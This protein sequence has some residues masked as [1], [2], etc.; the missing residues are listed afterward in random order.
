MCQGNVDSSAIKVIDG[1][2]VC[3]NCAEKSGGMQDA[4]MS[5]CLA[6]NTQ[7]AT[8]DLVEKDGKKICAACASH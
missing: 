4:D 2:E 7:V 3:V 5:D 6:C 8:K 1:K